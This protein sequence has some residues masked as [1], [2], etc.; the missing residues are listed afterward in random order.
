M[1]TNQIGCDTLYTFLKPFVSLD[2]Y[3]TITPALVSGDWADIQFCETLK[4]VDKYQI[5]LWNRHSG[6]MATY[7]IFSGY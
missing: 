3:A 6:S 7:A 4:H 5:T 1:G 2:Y